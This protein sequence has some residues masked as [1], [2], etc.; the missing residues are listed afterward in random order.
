MFAKTIYDP[1]RPSVEAVLDSSRYFVVRVEG[2]GKKA[3][4]GMGFMERSESFDFSRCSGHTECHL[5]S[6]EPQM[7]HCRTIQSSLSYL[8]LSTS[9]E[10]LNSGAFVQRR[11]QHKQIRLQLPRPLVR[12]KTTA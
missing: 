12:R 11:T 2:D 8:S 4:I 9:I 6:L 3:Y 5:C 10:F 1:S 7:S